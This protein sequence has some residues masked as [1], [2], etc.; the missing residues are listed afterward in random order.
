MVA[1][2][3]LLIAQTAAAPALAS[4][5]RPFVVRV[6]D[7][8]TARGIP[9]VELRTIHHDLFVT[10]SA[11]VAVINEPGLFGQ[12]VYFGVEAFGYVIPPDKQRHRG[13]TLKVVSGGE[14]VLALRR[15]NVAER[16]YRVTGEG[17]YRD[18][19]L[20]GMP[21]PLSRPVLDAGV[22]GQDKV[23]S[24]PFRGKIYW[25][26]GH[27]NKPGFAETN[28]HVTGATSL[29]F[30]RGGLDPEA[31]VD[32]DYFVD[33][34]GTARPTCQMPGEG[35]TRITGLAVLP[36]PSAPG[37]ERMFALYEKSRLLSGFGRTFFQTYQQGFVEFDDS[38][39][40][41]RKV[42]TLPNDIPIRPTGHTF[43]HTIAGVDHVYFGSPFPVVRVRAVPEAY[44]DPTKYEAFTP[45]VRGSEAGSTNVERDPAGKVVWGW[46]TGTAPA[47]Q[48]VQ[49]KLL[50]AKKLR[51][52][53]VVMM[54]RD[55]TTGAPVQAHS[56]SIA[57]NP[58]RKRWL[59]VF[60]EDFGASPVG[61]VWFAEADGPLGPWAFARK[62]VS[63]ADPNRSYSFYHPEH[64]PF[65]DKDGGRS[66]FFEATYSTAESSN[67]VPT[68]RYDYNQI[69]YKLD[70]GRPEAS[71]PVPVYELSDLGTAGPLGTAG[72]DHPERR[73]RPIAFFAFDG[74]E[75]GTLPIL[76]E[77]GPKGGQVLRVARPDE[78]TKVIFHILSNGSPSL[79]LTSMPLLEFLK[80]DGSGAYAGNP[81]WDA[82]GYRRTG[83]VLGH[84]W[85]NPMGRTIPAD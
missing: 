13:R 70:L 47:G 6:L 62:I 15:F 36:D 22:L 3:S 25:F 5:P 64:H 61:E 23:I 82:P 56:G 32:L 63:H 78:K 58:Y 66:I 10:D 38:A 40:E 7:D 53:E 41:F 46:K 42:K 55:V 76:Q 71:L 74:P 75:P 37:R 84:V 21:T 72:G 67:N 20:A 2:A 11:G 1:F 50:A 43:H 27:T 24:T 57:W 52:E 81:L 51:R 65:F 17:I 44:L 26:W 68:P 59:M 9:M 79:P 80:E 85:K 4:P 14:A 73:G 39:R 54:T 83:K 18:S 77:P 12:E 8:E 69:M 31:G 16:I 45:L 60:V 35:P 49:T 33:K 29:P 19:V 28:P 48:E 30:N 34:E